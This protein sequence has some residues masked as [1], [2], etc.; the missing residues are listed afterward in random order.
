MTPPFA[1]ITGKRVLFAVLLPFLLLDCSAGP[2]GSSQKKL[3]TLDS[4][5]KELRTMRSELDQFD[6]DKGRRIRDTVR[7]EM[8]RIKDNFPDTVNKDLWPLIS[9]YKGVAEGIEDV[10]KRYHTLVK[11][12]KY[13]SGQLEDL[14]K[15]LRAGALEKDKRE[16]Y[17]RKE[18]RSY[19]L[20]R[21]AYVSFREKAERSFFVHDSLRE[22][23][24]SVL[25]ELKKD[26]SDP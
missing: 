20:L 11:E 23:V 22:K 6:L 14:K 25:V 2:E 26:R 21:E 16:K 24:D 13:T 18:K 17:F 8:E 12:M 19:K 10:E 4:L 15:D 5:Q 3:D 9:S 1:Y 7:N